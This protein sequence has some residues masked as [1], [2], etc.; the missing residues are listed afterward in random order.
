MV[1]VSW[2][3]RVLIGLMCVAA[4]VMAWGDRK[5]REHRLAEPKRL[6]ECF[7]PLYWGSPQLFS[8]K[9]N[10][11]RKLAVSSFMSML[12]IFLFTAAL[13]SFPG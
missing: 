12:V 4:L 6:L 1:E 13:C 5:M 7:A 2:T 10:V 8:A 11:Y 3:C 9:G